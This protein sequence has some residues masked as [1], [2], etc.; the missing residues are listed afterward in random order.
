M[1]AIK[2]FDKAK[3]GYLKIAVPK[4]FENKELEINVKIIEEDEGINKEYL[5]EVEQRGRALS[6]RFG[7][8]KFKDYII[9]EDDVYY[10]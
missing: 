7:K 9:R 10:Q 1:E 6:A 5:D 8:A 2:L 4:N 3:N